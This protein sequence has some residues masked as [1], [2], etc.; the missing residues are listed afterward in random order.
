MY[1]TLPSDNLS[2]DPAV[3]LDPGEIPQAEFIRD[4]YDRHLAR[5]AAV[6]IAGHFQHD[7]LACLTLEKAVD[8]LRWPNLATVD[9]Q[10]ILTRCTLTP[11]CV[12]GAR[13]C[14]FQFSPL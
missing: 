13:S 10:Q 8:V 1:A 12:S 9:G 2:T 4:R 3:L 14:G 5:V 7:G 11:G 6:S